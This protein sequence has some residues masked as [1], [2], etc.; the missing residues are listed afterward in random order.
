MYYV[1]KAKRSPFASEWDGQVDLT[2]FYIEFITIPS[3]DEIKGD[4]GQIKRFY[5][6]KF[7]SLKEI[8]FFSNVLEQN[9]NYVL[10]QKLAS[11]PLFL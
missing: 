5:H 7:G 6:Q 1:N 8:V 3:W 2:F 10:F 4:Q 11:T 9:T